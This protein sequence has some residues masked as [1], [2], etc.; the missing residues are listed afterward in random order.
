MRRKRKG[1][2]EGSKRKEERSKREWREPR[3]YPS[4]AD[5]GQSVDSS[6]FQQRDIF[7]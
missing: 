2:R 4:A 1:G 3:S 5:M 7:R 6:D